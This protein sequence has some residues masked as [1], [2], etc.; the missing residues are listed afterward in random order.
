VDYS[1]RGIILS[2][3]IISSILVFLLSVL[4]EFTN[5][6][7]NTDSSSLNLFFS[8]IVAFAT[9]IN[10]FFSIIVAISTVFYAFLTWG[11]V[12]ETRKMRKV[13][14]EP[15]V[16]LF[17]EP[18]DEHNEITD[19]FIQNIGLGAAYNIGFD[20][21]SDYMYYE[22]KERS[23]KYWASDVRILKDGIKYLAPNQKK[24]IFSTSFNDVS[25]F[26]LK[27]HLEINIRYENSMGIKKEFKFPISFY[28]VPANGMTTIS[29]PFERRLVN[30]VEKIE[31][32]THTIS[33]K[34]SNHIDG[35]RK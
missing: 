9:L 19:L 21:L 27:N 7:T 14:T 18:K 33:S 6:I 16:Y 15:N 13:Q 11:L 29:D 32:D 24:R 10:M 8:G 25:E 20:V 5:L 17:I 35:L 2:T 30:S 31:K 12:S 28:E 22:S 23:K 4:I 3:L 26:N 34:I 1:L